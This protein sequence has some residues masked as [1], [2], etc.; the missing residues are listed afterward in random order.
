MELL[1]GTLESVI[2]IQ[3]GAATRLA[4]SGAPGLRATVS[5]LGFESPEVEV[6]TTPR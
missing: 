3:A 6:E 1:A 2:E 4:E 5:I